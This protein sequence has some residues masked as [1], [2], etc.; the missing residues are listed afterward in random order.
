MYIC[1]LVCD[2][3]SPNLTMIKILLGKKG[4]FAIDPTATDKHKLDSCMLHKSFFG[5]QNSYYLSITS[6]AVTV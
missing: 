4:V 1:A 2:G 6:G 3:A 5:R